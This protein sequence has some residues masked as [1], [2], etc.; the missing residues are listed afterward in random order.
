MSSSLALR[1]LTYFG[2]PTAG[3]A[4]GWYNYPQLKTLFAGTVE[5]PIRVRGPDGKS[6]ASTRK[7]TRL[8]GDEVD[9]KLRETASGQR[10][11]R[12]NG[13]SEFLCSS[14]LK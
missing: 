7:F 13:L 1:R 8:S 11:L 10:T 5:V 9:Q 6:M 2:L 4:L 12:P 14:L 3:V